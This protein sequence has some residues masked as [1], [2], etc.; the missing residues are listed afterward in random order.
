[1]SDDFAF[2]PIP[3]LPEHL[4]EGE[5]I[6]WQGGP[7]WRGVA[8]HVLHFRKQLCFL[9]IILAILLVGGLISGSALISPVAFLVLTAL[10]VSIAIIGIARWIARTTIY[11][12]TNRRLVMRFG[13]ALPMTFNL[14]FQSIEAAAVRVHGD[15]SG[16]IPL[17][18]KGNDRLAWLHLWPH[19]QPWKLRQPRPML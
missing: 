8:R 4:P 13:L 19:A 14:P 7:E 18:L 11:T 6:L 9:A 17:T 16:D 5:Y 1:M 12:I 10:I 15:G 3:G 2:E